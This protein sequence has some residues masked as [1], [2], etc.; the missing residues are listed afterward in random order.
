MMTQTINKY[1]VLFGRGGATNTNEGNKRFRG[2]VSDHQS[3]YLE[4]TKKEK[5]MIARDVV[6]IVRQNGGRFLKRSSGGGKTWEDVGD[7][8]AVAKT[9]Q[10]LREG[11]DVRRQTENKNDN[12]RRGSSSESSSSSSTK[13]RRRTTTITT[14]EERQS[15]PSVISDVDEARL[16]PDLLEDDF[17]PMPPAHFSFDFLPVMSIGEC[18][19]VV[20]V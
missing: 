20:E 11:L 16:L 15:P 4:A 14:A 10:A 3:E 17:P 6:K 5:G 19:H 2:I 12:K 18:E 9:S 8:M 13:K 7:K 1:D